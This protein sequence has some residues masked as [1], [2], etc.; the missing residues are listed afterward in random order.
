L[1][2]LPS[3]LPPSM[4]I[5]DVT[6]NRL[7]ILP[8]LPDA[9]KYFECYNFPRGEN[10][11]DIMWCVKIK[12]ADYAY[13]APERIARF[14]RIACVYLARQA[15]ARLIQR[16]CERW[17]DAPTTSDGRLGI[18][19]RIGMRKYCGYGKW[20]R[21]SADKDLPSLYPPEQNL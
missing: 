13:F 14:H 8:A 17:L 18:R 1:T 5:L 2:C 15:A 3:K 11:N 12:D 20:S 19:L 21:G 16:N 10:E 9:I 6:S 4:N 7:Q